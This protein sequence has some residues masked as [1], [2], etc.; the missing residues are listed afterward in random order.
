MAQ[1][2]KWQESFDIEGMSPKEVVEKIAATI[3]AL[4]Y[5][6]IE[7]A[8]KRNEDLKDEIVEKAYSDGWSDGYDT[9]YEKGHKDGMKEAVTTITE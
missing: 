1:K 7:F 8:H 5:S 6:A 9:G 2:Q 4:N 3:I